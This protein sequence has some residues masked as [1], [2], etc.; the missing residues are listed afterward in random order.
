MGRQNM[1]ENDTS[2]DREQT[3]NWEAVQS[4]GDS[5][6]THS[7]RRLLQILTSSG[8]FLL[9]GCGQDSVSN[10]TTPTSSSTKR[11][12]PS[13]GRLNQTLRIPVD[14]NPAHTSFY[15]PNFANE[16]E[17]TFA[18]T[19]KQPVT[20]RLKLSIREP[21]LWL[22]RRWINSDFYYTWL[23][24]ITVTPNE[25]TVTIRDNATWSDGHT[26]TGADI[27]I[28]H[29]AR[30]LKNSFDPPYYATEENVEPSLWWDAFD[31]FD[32]TDKSVTYRSSPGF[33][34]QF[35]DWSLRMSFGNSRVSFGVV[36][37]H[38]EPYDAFSEA[39][40]ET[41]RR[42]QQGEI[43]PWKGWDDLRV[44][45]DDPNAAS[46]I[47]KYLAK[48]GKYVAKFSDPEHV[49]STSA[50]DLAEI[51]G[52]EAVY[53]PN[54]YHR[55]GE[56]INFDRLIL[57]YTASQ[58]RARAAL[59][60]DRLDYAAPGP[61]PP[62][63]V[64]SLPDHFTQLQ[65]PGGRNTG[66]E[67]LLNFNH[68]AIGN[69]KVRKALMYAL[70]HSTIAN[71]I[72]QSTAIPVKTPGGDCWD[73]TDYVSE[74]WIDE[75]LIT[76]THDQDRAASLMQE[77]GYTKEDGQWVYTDGEPLTLPL[78][79]PSGT[80]RWEPTV[81]SQLTEFGIQ[82]SVQTLQEMTFK[83]RVDDGGFPLWPHSGNTTS[84][85]DRTLVFWIEDP[86][87]REKTGLYPKEQYQTGRFS[88]SGTPLPLTE[89]R[90]EVFTI[91]APPIGQRDGPLQEYHPAALAMSIFSNPPEAEFRRNVKTAMWLVNWLLPIIPINKTLEQHFIDDAHW[92]WP[93]NTPAWEAFTSSGPKSIDE[94]FASGTVQANPDNPEK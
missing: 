58:E 27:A 6:T 17:S 50:W 22:D 83:R 57:E 23:D 51:N 68:P 44:T 63:V 12:A 66:N 93:T 19:A 26:I 47:E 73:T 13:S 45:P 61:T 4:Q 85:A 56:T 48:E 24:D 90:Y 9:A 77:A 46:L 41:A 43:N 94:I 87:Q 82:M 59:T 62:A 76:Y 10:T 38:I 67:L 3:A 89:D 64:E 34:D 52:P 78:P 74:A 92:H 14:Q 29:I 15:A 84:L 1:T 42:A 7:R 18:I 31:D 60:A 49:L 71:N 11:G 20:E 37:T 35:F 40:F 33:F 5:P 70:D 36:P 30:H 16:L 32:I 88:V 72:H 54:P 80:P 28:P 25:V 79:T 86:I 55:N 81:A 21:G 53:E 69:R 8:A 91:E 65:I 2:T 75:N 39:V